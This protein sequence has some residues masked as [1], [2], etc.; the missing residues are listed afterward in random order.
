MT[1]DV[2]TAKHDRQLRDHV[3]NLKIC[4]LIQ[5]NFFGQGFCQGDS[6]GPLT[7]NGKLVGV[8]SWNIKGGCAL[9]KPDVY[10][11]ISPHCDWIK[12]HTDVSCEPKQDTSFKFL[13]FI[14]GLFG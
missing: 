6:G 3:T 2:C 10:E 5:N 14:G 7:L 1:N 8:V 12:T 13:K 9:G 4:T 11:R